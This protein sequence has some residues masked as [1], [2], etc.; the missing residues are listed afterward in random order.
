MAATVSGGLSR[1]TV[2]APTTRVDLSLPSDVPLA[3]LLPTLLRYAGEDLADTGVGHGG[4]ALTRLGSAP[5]DTGRSVVQLEIRDGDVLYLTPRAAVGPEVAFDDVVDAVAT[6]VQDRAAPWQVADTRTFGTGFGLAALLG[7]VAV[8]LFA[9]PPQLAGALVGLGAGAVLLVVALLLA[10]VGGRTRTGALLGLVAIGY[11][12]VGGLLL[13]AGERRLTELSTPDLLLAATMLVVYA[14]AAAAAVG[15]YPEL[16]LGAIVIGVVLGMGTGIGLLFD[17]PPAA[18]A[19]VV[20][21]V[22][23]GL[24]PA[25]PMLAY[26]IAGLP[27]PAIPTRPDDLRSDTES[28]AGERVLRLTDRAGG[29]LAGLVTTLAIVV[30]GSVVVIMIDAGWPGRI[31]STVLGL[32]LL[33][34]ARPVRGRAQRL[35][36]LLAGSLALGATAIGG[37]LAGDPAARLGLLLG[38]LAAVA[39]ISLGYGLGVAGRRISPSWGRW[40]DIAEI[41]LI[42]AVVPLAAWVAGVYGWIATIGR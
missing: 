3:D 31:L 29:I 40:L 20:A 6:G 14:A 24:F 33:L 11:G 10:R 37:F 38:G 28:V 17:A 35:P 26:R 15:D 36:A 39:A 5:L 7:G 16:F 19:A 32:L 8:A 2:V 34:R 30:L 12:G 27:V 42:L 23:F 18:A 25:L 4:W 1:V 9:G 21:A 22:A 41:L 13:V